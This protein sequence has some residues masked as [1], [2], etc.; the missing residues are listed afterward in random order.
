MK[1]SALG[2]TLVELLVVIESTRDP[3]NFSSPCPT[4]WLLIGG[5]PFAVG[6]AVGAGN[7]LADTGIKGWKVCAGSERTGTPICKTNILR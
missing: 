1:K 4:G 7:D 2:F 3:A 6:T 5:S